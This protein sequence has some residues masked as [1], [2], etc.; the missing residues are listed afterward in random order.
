MFTFGIAGGEQGF[1]PLLLLLIALILEAY[2][3]ETGWL[4]K[5]GWHPANAFG[6]LIQTFDRKLNREHRSD[7]DRALRGVLVTVAGAGLA[8]ALGWAIAWLSQNHA[9]GWI[10]ET[11]LLVLLLDQRGR[12]D[13]LRA[14]ADKLGEQGL[15]PVQEA[16]ARIAGQ[17]ECPIDGHGVAR[18]AIESAARNFCDEV[19]VL[20]FWYTLFGFPGFLVCKVVNIMNVRI[21]H[22]TPHYRAFGLT[23]V[24]LN[25]ALA[26]IPARLA[27]LFIVIAALFTPTARLGQAWKIMLRDAGK[28]RSYNAGW[29][30]AAMAGALNLSLAGPR[31]LAGRTVAEPWIGGGSAQATDDDIR[32][33]LYLYLVA[34]LVN[35]MWVAAFAIVRLALPLV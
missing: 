13:H 11:V 23:A 6:A 21:G 19:V 18:A 15:E 28:Y 32:R 9:F 2:I 16:M 22:R 31:S 27:G 17:G 10:V 33:A 20:V 35:V 12:Y 29:P 1:D 34:C 14:V 30:V 4:V 8:L 24:R 25:D 3:G 7:L 5:V 26:L